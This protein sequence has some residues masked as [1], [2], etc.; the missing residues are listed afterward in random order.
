MEGLYHHTNKQVHEVQS[1]MGRL[2]TSDRDSVH[3]VENEI[4]ARIDNIFSSLERLEILSSKEPPSK[5][6]NA[7]L[8]VEQLKYDVQHLQSALRTCTQRR[9][10]REQQERQRQE[11]LARTFAPNGTQ[12]KLLDVAN[13][14]GLSNTVMRLIEKRAFQ[15]KYFMAGGMLLTCLLMLLILHYLS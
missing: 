1:Y 3:L 12:K 5:R 14:L 10:A 13:M 9:L 4:Q 2:E 6:Q 7:K 8:R 11:L 15:D